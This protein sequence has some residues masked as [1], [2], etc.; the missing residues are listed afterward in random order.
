[1]AGV[2]PELPTDRP[3][4]IAAFDFPVPKNQFVNLMRRTNDMPIADPDALYDDETACVTLLQQGWITTAPGHLPKPGGGAAQ[5]STT[6]IC[7]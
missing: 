3:L 7:G 4:L 5:R 2:W 6:R 1:V